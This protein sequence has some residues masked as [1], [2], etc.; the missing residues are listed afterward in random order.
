MAL[1]KAIFTFSKALCQMTQNMVSKKG[2]L[3]FNNRIVLKTF[4]CF[5]LNALR[6]FVVIQQKNN[7]AF[8]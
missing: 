5:Y 7:P 2:S 6:V 3:N 8:V 4:V 1:Y